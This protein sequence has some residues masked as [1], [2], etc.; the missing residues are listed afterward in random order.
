[1]A[2]WQQIA[3]PFHASG[4]VFFG[5]RDP[6]GR[7]VLLGYSLSGKVERQNPDSTVYVAPMPEW[8]TRGDVANDPHWKHNAV[9]ALEGEREFIIGEWVAGR[10]QLM[11][12]HASHGVH[13]WNVTRRGG[14]MHWATLPP[15]V[16][17]GP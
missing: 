1:M 5:R 2:E 7:W 14:Q 4:P 10:W 11:G 13:R 12:V 15:W 6:D 8:I 3:V 16:F 17:K 9:H